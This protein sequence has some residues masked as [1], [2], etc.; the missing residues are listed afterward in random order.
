[1]FTSGYRHKAM[2]MPST[3]KSEVKVC[4]SKEDRRQVVRLHI[5]HRQASTLTK[6]ERMIKEV[7]K[8]LSKHS[9]IYDNKGEAIVN[10]NMN[11]AGMRRKVLLNLSWSRSSRA[12]RSRSSR[13]LQVR[14][15]DPSAFR[16]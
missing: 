8:T 13:A 14:W 7:Q 4:L 6:R 5:H 1:M 10:A 3:K 16:D 2:S 15:D 11:A 12:L 9:T